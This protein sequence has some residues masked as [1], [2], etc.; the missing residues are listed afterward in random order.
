MKKSA[1]LLS[2]GLGLRMQQTTPKQY[3]LLHGVPIAR[4]AFD[5]LLTIQDWQEIVIV[6]DPLYRDLFPSHSWVR[7]ALPGK[8]RFAS[9]MHGVQALTKLC[10]LV[11]IHDAARPLLQTHDLVN[12]LHEGAKWGAAALAVPVRSTI[13]EATKEGIVKQTLDRSTLWETQTPQ[14]LH[15]DL[16]KQGLAL[17]SLVTDD[18]ALAELLG[19]KSKLVMGSYSNLKITTKEDFALAKLLCTPTNSL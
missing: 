8:E 9:V 19:H 6:C 4:R 2:G 13:K 16:L 7:F 11:C 17:H 15:Y 1:I 14:V 10:S 18:I 5:A 3:L 12:V